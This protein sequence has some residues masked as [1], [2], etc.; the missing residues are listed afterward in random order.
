MVPL[1]TEDDPKTGQPA[2]S[3][4]VDYVE[5]ILA[6]VHEKCLLTVCEVSEEVG[7]SRSLCHTILT[8]RL[9]KQDLD[10]AT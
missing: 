8:E 9:E 3:I 4:E 10:A 7:I 1:T 2:T 6:V 5:K